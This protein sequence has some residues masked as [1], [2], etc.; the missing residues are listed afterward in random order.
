MSKRILGIAAVLAAALMSFSCMS[1]KYYGPT[2]YVSFRSVDKVKTSSQVSALKEGTSPMVST[3]DDEFTY[4]DKGNLIKFKQT[5]YIDR[6]AKDKK[7]IVWETESKV[8]GGNAVPYRVSANGVPFLEV[9]YDLLTVQGNGAVVEDITER[10]FLRIASSFLTGT[11]YE[12]WGIALGNYDV[13]FKL[14]GKFVKEVRRFSPYSG[15]YY[16]NVLTLGYDNIVL[17]R[18]HYSR[19]KLAEGLA[20][21]YTG[22]N[23]QSEMAKKLTKGI[24]VDYTYEWKAI[25]DRICQTKMTYLS[26]TLKLEA[27]ED[28]DT[29]GKRIKETWM[30]A[31][32]REKTPVPLK[33]FEQTLTY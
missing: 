24:N 23:Y 11:D 26:M 30:L 15:V 19:E 28:Y 29:A 18:F 21:S 4:D 6:L 17:K 33:V 3:Y 13:P 20:K 9:E 7:F 25:A 5:E 10:T 1:T 2:D 27:A 22:Y 16:E 31:D 14:D 32:P 12:P 8:M